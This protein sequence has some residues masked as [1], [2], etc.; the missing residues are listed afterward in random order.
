LPPD[1]LQKQYE[2][3]LQEYRFQ[4][5]LNWDRTKHYLVFNTALFG[6]AVA[7]Y[8]DASTWA[9]EAAVGFLLLLVALNSIAGQRAVAVGHEYYR[10][11]RSTKTRLEKELGLDEFAIASTPG[12]RREHDMDAK[13]TPRGGTIARD[14]RALLVAIAVFGGGGA[15][16][17]LHA[18]Y[19]SY[20]TPTLAAK[21][22]PPPSGR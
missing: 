14:I 15:L 11:I 12:M 3:V 17:A 16:Y 4:I 9:P 5:Q 8:K 1:M 21:S 13:G 2:L 6:A 22:Q 20:C 19:V 18:S 10:G 7:L